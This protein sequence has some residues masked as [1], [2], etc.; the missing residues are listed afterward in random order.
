MGGLTGAI[1]M[2]AAELRAR[3]GLR[4]PDAI[5]C[6][7]ALAARCDGLLT[8]DKAFLRISAELPIYL[9]DASAQGPK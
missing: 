5:H 7:T 9:F 4:T 1:A 2:R 8:N 3:Y 6:A